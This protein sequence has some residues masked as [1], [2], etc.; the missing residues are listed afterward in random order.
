M[1]DEIQDTGPWDPTEMWEALARYVARESDAAEALRVQRWLAADP[2]RETLL[3]QLDAALRHH[4]KPANGDVDVEAALERVHARMRVPGSVRDRATHR[5]RRWYTTLPARAAAVMAMALGAGL[6]WHSQR[7]AGSPAAVGANMTWRTGVG[8]LDSLHLPDGSGVVLG[9]ESRMTVPAGFGGSDRRVLLDG[10]AWFDVVS[11]QVRPFAV[12]TVAATIVAIGT[13]FI[14]R[15]P[16][17][18]SVRV[19]VT[20]GAVRIGAGPVAD[21][22]VTLHRGDRAR[23]D[24]DGSTVVDAGAASDADVAWTRGRLV[25]DDAPIPDV[26]EELRRW[27]G[28]RLTWSD[29]SLGARHVTA[30]FDG[31]SAGEVLAVLAAVLGVRVELADDMAVLHPSP[32]TP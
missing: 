29:P 3:R 1:S 18:G 24:A 13:T 10:E 22:G 17:D 21:G 26:A 30:S 12:H 25:F 27:Y 5:G 7:P 9:P 20:A 31:E 28:I 2:V 23:I 11:D 32:A 8:Q 16:A 6:V 19:T 14:V 4:A 15:T